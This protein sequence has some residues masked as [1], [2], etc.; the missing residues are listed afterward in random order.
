MN[1]IN[2]I[3][4]VLLS[5]T[6]VSGLWSLIA[7]ILDECTLMDNL[8]IDV[9]L[10][11]MWGTF[12]VSLPVLV[13]VGITDMIFCCEPSNTV[14]NRYDTLIEQIETAPFNQSYIEEIIDWNTDVEKAFVSEDS[15][16]D[17]FDKI[18]YLEYQKQYAA[19]YLDMVPADGSKIDTGMVEISKKDLEKIKEH[20]NDLR[21]EIE[22]Q[23]KIKMN[24]SDVD[25]IFN[26]IIKGT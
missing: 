14:K 12:L 3:F 6:V 21:K 10:F 8:F 7:Y 15:S 18:D 13:I 19:K 4:W 25:K 20:I 22:N 1:V 9:G 26:S 2:T 16:Y 17:G 23:N 5:V 24:N 11:A